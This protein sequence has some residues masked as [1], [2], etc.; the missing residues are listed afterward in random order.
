MSGKNKKNR[1]LRGFLLTAK[2]TISK[3]L[4]HRES[5][6]RFP[7]IPDGLHKWRKPHSKSAASQMPPKRQTIKRPMPPSEGSIAQEDG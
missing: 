2:K 1:G 5:M 6:T 7:E 4:I 3:I